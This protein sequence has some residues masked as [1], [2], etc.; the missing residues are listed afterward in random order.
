MCEP[1]PYRSTN[2]EDILLSSITYILRLY[3]IFYITINDYFL[4]FKQMLG[5][6]LLSKFKI[7]SEK[8]CEGF[9]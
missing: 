8:A 5:R 2:S 7:K 9:V 1:G 6:V 4:P 3:A